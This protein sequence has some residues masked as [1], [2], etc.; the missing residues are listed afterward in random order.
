[1]LFFS[2]LLAAVTLPSAAQ[3]LFKTAF[4]NATCE[5]SPNTPD[6]NGFVRFNFFV[7]CFFPSFFFFLLILLPSAGFVSSIQLA[8]HKVRSNGA[9]VGPYLN[10]GVLSS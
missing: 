5:Y 8:Q 6:A 3:L 4:T 9:G 7:F 10:S 2:L 1:M